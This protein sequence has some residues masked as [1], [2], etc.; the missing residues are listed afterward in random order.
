MPVKNSSRYLKFDLGRLTS[1]KT[2]EISLLGRA[3]N[4]KLINN[5]NMYAYERGRDYKFDGGLVTKSTSHIKIPYNDHWFI[6]V[7]T[8]GLEGLE[9]EIKAAVKVLN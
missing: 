2:V 5:S 4:V 9:G 1:G 3:V 7:D 8:I 6:V